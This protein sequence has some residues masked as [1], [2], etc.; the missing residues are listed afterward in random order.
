M[1]FLIWR[2]RRG[3]LWG[4]VR[5]GW[6][7]GACGGSGG[8]GGGLTWLEMVELGFYRGLGFMEFEN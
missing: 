1:R 4:R 8:D 3:V 6:R 2:L 7:G 5:G